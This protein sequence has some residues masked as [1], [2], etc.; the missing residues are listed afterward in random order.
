[1][2]FETRIMSDTVDVIVDIFLSRGLPFLELIHD[3]R[4]I[5]QLFFLQF[6][7]FFQDRCFCFI[8]LTSGFLQFL[9]VGLDLVSAEIATI[10][11]H[12]VEEKRAGM[13]HGA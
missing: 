2:I 3:L 10:G 9:S 4:C 8:D 6:L 7:H 13:R 5:F 12:P 1:M 11:E